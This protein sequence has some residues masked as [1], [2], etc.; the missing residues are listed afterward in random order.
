MNVRQPSPIQNYVLVLG[1]AVL[2]AVTNVAAQVSSHSG[3]VFG[4]AV[5][6]SDYQNGEASPAAGVVIKITSA[7]KNSTIV[8]NDAGVIDKKLPAGKYC[9]LEA[10]AV[11]GIVLNFKAD[12]V[13]C[14]RIKSAKS[15]RFD[16]SI[17]K[18]KA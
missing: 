10:R 2:S 13:M 7:R 11:G 1:F 16:I 15:S 5:Y 3:Y 6:T 12:Q 18:P 14:F 9:L 8:I 4:N 17:L